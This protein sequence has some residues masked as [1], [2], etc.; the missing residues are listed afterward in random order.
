MEKIRLATENDIPRI[1]ELYEELTEEKQNVPLESIHR[2]FAEIA[3]LPNQQF[4]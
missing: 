2:V 3:A 4:L 1:L